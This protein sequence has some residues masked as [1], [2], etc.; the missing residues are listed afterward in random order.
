MRSFR[1]LLPAFLSFAVAL[2]VAAA[3]ASACHPQ[4]PAGVPQ[5]SFTAPAQA[6]YAQPVVA[7][8]VVTQR[9]VVPRQVYRQQVVAPVVAAPVVQAQAVVEYAPVAAVTGC[10]GGACQR[11]FATP[12]RN[13]VFRGSR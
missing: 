1:V 4:Q 11:N 3:S 13:F 10:V 7:Q 6:V 5:F 9:V 12:V 2:L 8:Q